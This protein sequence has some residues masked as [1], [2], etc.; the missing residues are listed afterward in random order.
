MTRCLTCG[1]RAEGAHPPCG[2][3]PPR[4]PAEPP[5]ALP[6]VPGYLVRGL[7][8]RGGFATVFEAERAADGRRVALKVARLDAAGAREQLEREAEALRAIG[9]PAVPALLGRGA[10]GDGA[11]YLALELVE[12][13]SLDALLLAGG[14]ALP[15]AELGPAVLATLEALAAIHGAGWAHGDL[16]PENVLLAGEPRV[17]RLVDLGLAERLGARAAAPGPGTPGF[18]GTAEYMSPEQCQGLSPDARS[19]VY[20]AGALLLELAAGRP[21]F[22]GPAPEVR[23]AH[24]NLRPPPPAS[25]APMPA[26]LAQ[27]ILRCLAKAPED[28]FPSAAAL[29]EAVAPSLSGS[30]PED[31][32][33]AAQAAPPPSR[34]ARRSVGVVYLESGAEVGRLQAA[35]AQ[36]GGVLAH[37]EG[38]RCAWVFDPAAGENPVRL[39]LHAARSAVAAGLAP[40]GLVDLVAVLARPRPGGADR[41]LAAAFSDPGS[42]PAASDPAG[43]LATARAA[44]VLVGVGLETVPGRPDLFVCPLHPAGADE[45]TVV[46]EGAPPLLGRDEVLAR[47]AALA[48]DAARD[49]SPI[50]TS[51]LGDPGLGKSHLG[52]ALA[53]R[54]RALTPAPLVLELRARTAPESGDALAALLRWLL[55]VPAAAAAPPDAGRSLLALALPPELR[56]EAWPAVAL[57]LGWLAPGAP[58]LEAAG[59]APGALTALAIRAAASLLRRRA[60]A[61]PLCVLLDDAHL[62]GGAALD[63][64]E[65]AALA[66]ARAPLFVCALARPAFA[67]ARP[68]W[69]ERAAR[70]QLERLEPLPAATAAELCRRLLAPAEGIPAQAVERLAARAQ[71][72]PFLLVELVRGLRRDG[73]VRPQPQGRSWYLATDELDRVPDLP[74]V[75]WLAGTELRA[76]PPDLASHAQLLALLGDE[77]PLGEADGVLAQLAEAGLGGAF[78]LDTGAAVRRLAGRGLLVPPRR[79]G[80][81]RYRLPLVRDAVARST[82]DALRAAIHEAAFR[83]HLRPGSLPEPA[84]LLRLAV[85][86]Q[87]S[88]RRADAA[89]AFL[90]VSADQAGR[91]AYLQAE[92]LYSRA[93]ENL[94]ASSLP[95]RLEALRGRGLMR[96]RTARHRDA[97]ADLE[98]AC[99]VAREL[100]DAAAEREALLDEATALDWMSDFGASRAC[101]EAAEALPGVPSP[102]VQ[103][104]LDLGRG[105]S[106]FRASRWADAC[107]TLD[108]AA[109]LAGR[110]GDAGYET[111]VASLLLLGAALPYLGRPAQAEAALER[112]RA[113][114]TGRGD[115]VHVAVAH[116]NRR[117]LSVARGDLAAAVA[118]Q[119]EAIRIARELGHLDSEY[120]S[121][122]NLAELYYQAGDLAA[123]APHLARA[124]EI[125]RSHPEAAPGPLGLLLRA[126]A[127]LAG[128]DAAGARARLERYREARAAGWGGAEVGPS[129]AVLADMVELAAR[130]AADAE[131]EALLARSAR[132]S[133]EQEPVEVLEMRGLAALRAGRLDTARAA[134]EGAL[135]LAGRI[136]G[137]LAPRIRRALE[138]AQA[139]S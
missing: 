19:D 76:M 20:A 48:L 105:R 54:L 65:S 11:P 56:D 21:P 112:A 79:G 34:A 31:A 58:L 133:V 33:R 6:V 46:R 110:Q 60:A 9:P 62:A 26:A 22:F 8:G 45:T 17:A 139:A 113:V 29:L 86:G 109:A 47:L 93:L 53:E 131:W 111:L 101:V 35:A 138:A 52:A 121:E 87:E 32:P 124:E 14:G 36:L 115:L 116:S 12:A 69:G 61:R 98:A 108:R 80:G 135:E 38:R 102:R 72:V 51:V 30:S 134:L 39:A 7:L 114:A 118:G 75:E 3:A 68:Y 28:R 95:Q 122:F 107:A 78:P 103:A 82:P 117:N 90:Q 50:V 89:A 16:K 13:P 126:R 119:L 49:R 43:A 41:Y 99:A 1:R 88:G 85:H 129:E 100:G 5:A 55:D 77:V 23:H 15:R 97:V 40:R 64:L 44:E 63:A 92:A 71:G 2:S 73:L 125:E 96:S 120:A 94:P 91:H 81:T 42:W 106:L 137:L 57:T 136:P 127:L 123:A 27:A 70:R 66:E 24:V 83:F 128:G 4:P 84:R 37:A 25:L 130:G 67:A 59:A 18:A 74:L 132:D 10:L 104:R